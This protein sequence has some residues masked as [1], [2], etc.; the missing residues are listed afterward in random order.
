MLFIIFLQSFEL[1]LSDPIILSCWHHL[2]LAFSFS[3]VD[4][5]SAATMFDAFLR[6]KA[7]RIGRFPDSFFLAINHER[8]TY[9]KHLSR[10][11]LDVPRIGF[12]AR[13]T[14]GYPFTLDLYLH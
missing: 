13:R 2:L 10:L 8:I 11:I 3:A 1:W 9:I 5:R 12:A 14:N 6:A 4:C 7:M